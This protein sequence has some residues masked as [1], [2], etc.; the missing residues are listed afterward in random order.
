VVVAL[1]PTVAVLGEAEILKF[2][3]GIA[4]GTICIPLIGAR[5]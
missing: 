5:L 4:T 3:F 2:G 1:K